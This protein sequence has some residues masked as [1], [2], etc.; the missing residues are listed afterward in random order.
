MFNVFLDTL[1]S[2]IAA[3]LA[4]LYTLKGSSLKRELVALII[5]LSKSSRPPKGSMISFVR[6]SCA[7]ELIVISLL[8]K[9]SSIVI[10]SLVSMANSL[11][12]LPTFVS[13][14]ASAD[15]FPSRSKTSKDFPLTLALGKSFRNFSEVNPVMQKSSSLIGLSKIASRTAPPTK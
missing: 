8:F 14:L 6:T 7:I 12:P 2:K 3:I 15:S 10:S 11:W 9:S 1:K 5:P 4:T 13:F